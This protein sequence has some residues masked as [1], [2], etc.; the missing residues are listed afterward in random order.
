M[1]VLT[2]RN[3]PDEVHRALRLRAAQHGHSTE[4][5]IRE[6]LS[7]VVKPEKR[8]RLG[9]ALAALGRKIGLT[10]DDFAALD[11]ARDQT[12]AEPMRFE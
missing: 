10:N 4:A 6:I 2:V 12:P 7:S 5:E 11:Q 8:V 9:D 3:V 1:A